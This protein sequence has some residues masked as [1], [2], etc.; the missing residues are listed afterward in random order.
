MNDQDLK[1]LWQGQV[2]APPPKLPDAQLIQAMK[3]KMSQFGRTIFWRDVR[4]V[5]ACLLVIG[6]FLPGYFKP[7]SWLFQTGCLVEVL[8]AIFIAFRL[9][10]SK[11][12]DDRNL[13]ADSLRG[14]LLH[15]R[16]KLET[17]IRL[18]S[19]VL[20]WYILPLYI[21]A[22]MV[23]FG[24]GPGGMVHKVGFAIF[25]AIGCGGIWWLN[26]YAVKKHLLPLKAELDQTLQEIPES[27]EIKT[28]HE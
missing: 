18:L 19:T 25:Y 2:L 3:Q 10:Y 9:V 17:Q 8:S 4:E 22:V 7:T 15:E 21:G 5:A 14:Y 27:S 1:K 12:R 23:A 28:S 11:R 16:R 26:Q 24:V 13:T 6:L 20:W